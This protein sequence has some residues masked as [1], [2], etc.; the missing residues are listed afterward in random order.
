MGLTREKARGIQGRSLLK[1]MTS[2]EL[3]KVCYGHIKANAQ[4]GWL[5]CQVPKIRPMTKKT[6]SQVLKVLRKDGF[7]ILDKKEEISIGW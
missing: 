7:R 1:P 5:Y 6:L 3:L 4:S 2:E